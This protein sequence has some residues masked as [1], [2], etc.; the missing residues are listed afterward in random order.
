MRKSQSP[1]SP[2]KCELVK[3]LKKDSYQAVTGLNKSNIMLLFSPIF[4]CIVYNIKR[5]EIIH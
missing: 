5:Y 4:L 3:R 1:N 2:I